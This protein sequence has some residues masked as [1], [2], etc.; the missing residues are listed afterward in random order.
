MGQGKE[1]GMKAVL[2]SLQIAGCHGK[3]SL[4]RAGYRRGRIHIGQFPLFLGQ[5]RR[6]HNPRPAKPG[7]GGV[8][9]K[10]KSSDNDWTS[11]C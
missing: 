4:Q 2:I 5:K 1:Q 7:N 3:L 11:L 9:Q 10:W 6:D 8:G